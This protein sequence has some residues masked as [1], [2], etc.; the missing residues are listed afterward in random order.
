M[1][2]T[3]LPA[4]MP[5]FALIAFGYAVRAS[6]LMER[7][8]WGGVNALIHR[9]LLPALLFTLLARADFSGAQ[10]GGLALASAA[11]SL[12]MIT[13]SLITARVMKLKA[14]EAAAFLSVSVLWNLVLVLALAERLFEQIITANAAAVVTPGVVIGAITAVAAFSFARQEGGVS[15]GHKIIRDPVLIA[16]A[17][18]LAVNATGLAAL[19]GLMA[20]LDLAGSG[21]IA[22]ILLAMGAGLDFSALKGRIAVLA[23]GAL[24]RTL[25]GACVYLALALLFGFRGEHAALLALAGGAPAAA[26]TYA[27]ASDLN[28]ETGLTAGMITLSVLTSAVLLPAAAALALA[29]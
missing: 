15:A 5:V 25:V 8:L 24:M 11:G 6:G 4:F 1:F 9:V 14:G 26:F 17:A 28:G 2:T 29:L 21:A 18:G 7:S 10:A 20:P 19:P 23:A 12:M 13:L 3:I 27:V 22:A 16:C